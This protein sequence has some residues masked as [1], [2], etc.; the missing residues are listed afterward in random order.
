MLEKESKMEL[1]LITSLPCL[2]PMEE[3]AREKG[4]AGSM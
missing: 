2:L 4:G 1:K 3:Q